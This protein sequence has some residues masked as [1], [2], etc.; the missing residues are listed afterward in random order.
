VPLALVA[1]WLL[2][3]YVPLLSQTT[4]PAPPF[5]MPVAKLHG[6][7]AE[8]AVPLPDGDT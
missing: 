4:A 5:G 6:D 8:H 7:A 1:T 3:L 2:K